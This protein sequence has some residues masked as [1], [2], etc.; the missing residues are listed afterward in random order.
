MID[1]ASASKTDDS[2]GWD[3]GIV[4][5]IL[6][7]QF[8]G[9]DQ[10]G[11]GLP[12]SPQSHNVDEWYEAVRQLP[13]HSPQHSG[14]P[15]CVV[16]FINAFPEEPYDVIKPIEVRVI[17][18]APDDFTASFEKANV[19]MPGETSEDAVGN[20]AAHILDMYEVF[21]RRPSKQLGSTPRTQLTILRKHL[22]PRK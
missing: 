9:N 3:P 16:T 22:R 19:A 10:T 4:R 5:G 17:Q 12:W 11:P 18:N 14:A 7:S 8:L 15:Y 21:S 2:Y 13:N 6:A 1:E 20:L